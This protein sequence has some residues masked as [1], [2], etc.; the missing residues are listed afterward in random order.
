KV[1]DIR[2]FERNNYPLTVVAGSGTEVSLRFSYDRTRFESSAIGRM[3]EHYEELMNS[4]VMNPEQRIRE[5][6]MI[7]GAEE[8][9]LVGWNEGGREYEQDQCLHE[10]FEEQAERMPE[11]IALVFG[12]D[13]LTY[14]ELNG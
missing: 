10:L 9:E 5:L 7:G 13:E 11:Q 6:R 12:E 8:Q 1:D 14:G 3:I 4:V 2:F